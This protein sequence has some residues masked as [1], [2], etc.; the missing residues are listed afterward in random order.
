MSRQRRTAKEA[1]RRIL[2]VAE[3]QL[4]ERGA[5][6]VRVQDVADELGIVPATV[7]HHFGSREALLDEL[8]LYGSK[9]LR[10]RVEGLVSAAKPDLVR[11][12]ADLLD[13]YES[14][15]YAA[16]YASLSDERG[17]DS[18]V[19]SPV[20]APLLGR[21][22]ETHS[23]GTKR[24]RERVAYA[25]L[26]LNLTAFADALVG[27]PMREAVGLPDDDASRARFFRWL[28][29]LLDEEVDAT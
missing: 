16:L 18:D 3:K 15:G 10:E 17:G 23:L 28:G 20:F 9:R 22:C 13:L 4:A 2:E 6:G 14:R 5:E 26:A 24:Q 11:L 25:V 1:R 21:L 27:A 29:R 8:M 12:S 19:V 7:L